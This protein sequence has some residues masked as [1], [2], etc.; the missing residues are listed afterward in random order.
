MKALVA[1][2]TLT[3]LL[4]RVSAWSRPCQVHSAPGTVYAVFADEAD[5]GIDSF[6]GLVTPQRIA[7]FPDRIF[8]DLVPLA[9]LS[10]ISAGSGLDEVEAHFADQA[11]MALP[12]MENGR[13]IGAVT[14]ESLL[15]TLLRRD[16]ILMRQMQALRENLEADRSRLACWS[17]QL[18]S[19]HEISYGLLDMISHTDDM[20]ALM[21]AGIESL[22]KLIGSR[23]GAIGIVGDG[24]RLKRFLHAGLDEETVRR[25]GRLPTGKGL[26]GEVLRAQDMLRVDDIS[27][28]PRH[29]E[30]PPHHPPMER[31]V[32]AP[33][34]YRGRVLGHVYL[35]DK[36]SGAPFTDHD[37]LLT[38]TFANTLASLLV[39]VE[40][41]ARRR[42]A[43][44][45]ASRLL[46]ENQRLSRHLL[47]VLEEERRFIARELHDEMGQCTTAI[48]AEAETIN[49]L[50]AG[51][52]PR[53]HQCASSISDLG[54]RLYNVVHAMLRRLRPE[55]LD[56]LGLSE[57]VRYI[58]GTWQAHYPHI[59]CRLRLG[60]GL[61]DLDEA[62][63]IVV[64]RVVQE[65][66][67]NVARHAQA[68]AIAMRLSRR[69]RGAYG[70]C[71][72]LL[73]RDN[74]RGL[75][76]KRVGLGLV[77]LRE[78]VETLGGRFSIHSPGQG[79][80]VHVYIPVYQDSNPQ[81]DALRS[82]I[83]G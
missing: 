24:G 33:I 73:V 82:V 32:A 35:C 7:R 13:F 19:L 45:T 28:D 81:A 55:L 1:K 59:R 61:D 29:V 60:E 44:R 65:C 27:T 47:G 57:A 39:N 46:A 68:T 9:P 48:Q 83:S 38:L 70:E 3:P 54:S 36:E 78:R 52:D 22:R 20:Y 58:V 14:R 8:A 21:Q 31:L 4:A 71:L 62:I 30:F 67:T 56:D 79:T 69:S 77:G 12:V 37:A 40:E 25:I 10:A 43:E 42:E 66:L 17:E 16:R 63:G 49:A 75:T 6:L 2:D 72:S 15:K 41:Q 76:P 53:I 64:Y 51:L 74:G 23:Y 11:L 5:D 34:A 26:L 80:R 18:R 50:S